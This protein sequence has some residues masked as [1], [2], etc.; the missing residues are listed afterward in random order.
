MSDMRFMFV[1][2]ILLLFLLTLGCSSRDQTKPVYPT[3]GRVLYNSQPLAGAKVT[4]NP[5]DRVM[6]PRETPTAITDAEGN[7][8]MSTYG[9]GDGAPTG[10]YRVTIVPADHKLNSP[11]PL[12]Y[13]DPMRSG[14]KAQVN[15]AVTELPTFELKGPILK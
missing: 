8:V 6:L 1:S 7:F 5:I 12:I 10:Y 3:K 13:V 9:T 15:S 4:F 2:L 11:F 14:L